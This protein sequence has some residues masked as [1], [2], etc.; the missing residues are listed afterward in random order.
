M[1]YRLAQQKILNDAS[2]LDSTTLPRDFAEVHQ[3][4]MTANEIHLS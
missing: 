1:K 2:G 3:G 4:T